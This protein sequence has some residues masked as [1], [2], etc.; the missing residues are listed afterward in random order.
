MGKAFE[1]GSMLLPKPEHIPECSLPLLPY[2]LVGD[3]IFALKPWLMRPYPGKNIKEDQ[4]IFNYR[5][6]RA[7]RVIENCFGILVARWRTF[8]GPIQSKVETVQ[9]I[10]QA[11]IALHKYLRQTDTA[12]YCPAGFVDSFDDSG[13]IL[14][15][16]WRQITSTDDGSG[17]FCSLPATRGTRYRNHAMEMREALKAYVNAEQGAVSWQW[18]YIR[19][20]GPI[21]VP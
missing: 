13:N 17:A 16:E 3:E 20:R 14:P 7:R 9:K 5:L 21:R 15:G 11:T 19:R 1:D 6:S 10:V 12:C 8:R 2:Y 18:E 4:S